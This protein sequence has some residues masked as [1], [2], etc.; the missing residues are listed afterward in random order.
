M[1]HTTWGSLLG[2]IKLTNFY[3]HSYT[4][5]KYIDAQIRETLLQKYGVGKM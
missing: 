5:V 4:I 3:V 1:F 2:A